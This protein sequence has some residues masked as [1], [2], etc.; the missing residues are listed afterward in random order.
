MLRSD[1]QVEAN[2]DQL[3]V[4]DEGILLVPVQGLQKLGCPGLGVLGA[5]K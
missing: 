4:S 5:E 2:A 1:E 3:L